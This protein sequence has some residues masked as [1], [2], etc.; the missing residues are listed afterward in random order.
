MIER[1]SVAALTPNHA[2]ADEANLL[3]ILRTRT[4]QGP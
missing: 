4:S 2:E 1:Q 3:R